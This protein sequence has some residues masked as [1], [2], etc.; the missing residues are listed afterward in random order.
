MEKLLIKDAF[1]IDPA[2]NIQDKLDLLIVDGRVGAIAPGMVVE[3]AQVINAHG[4]VCAPGIVDMHVHLRDP[5][6][7]YKEDIQSGC[8]AA[9]AGGVTSVVCMPNTQPVCDNAKVIAD[10]INRA[11]NAPAHVYPV[12]AVTKSLE[13]Q[14]LTDFSALKAAGAIAVSDDGRPVSTPSAMMDAME[15]AELL[16]L[17]VLSH[18]EDLSLVR[19]GIMNDGDVSRKIGVSGIHRAAEEV[20][21]ARDI[22]L[23][24]ATGLPVHICHVSTRGSVALIRDAKRRGVPVTGETAPHYFMLT[25]QLLEKRDGD[26]RMNPPLR[27]QDDVTA[28]IEGLQDGTLSAIA[29]DHAPHSPG[30]KADFVHAPNGV[31]GLETSLAAGITALVKPGY[32]TLSKLL[33]LM[34]TNPANILGIPAGSLK[35]DSPADIVIFDS[36]QGWTVSADRLH[37]KSKNTPFKGM[38]LYGSVK[39]TLLDG[40]VVY[41]NG[42]I[43]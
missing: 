42:S 40:R 32:I 41:K 33:A 39:M 35:I 23:A 43:V 37:G 13:G 22:A 12:A 30:D 21:T 15:K 6:Q 28:V 36:S 3:D 17:K 14:S 34:S 26:Y 1:I 7:T 31:I 9:A 10:I 20:G 11:S 38:M 2:T 16:G 8:C 19:G 18:C 27:T 5:G 24:G 29:T 25:D 4:L